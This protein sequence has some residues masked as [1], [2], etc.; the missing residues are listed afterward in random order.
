MAN[1]MMFYYAAPSPQRFVAEAR[2]L[3]LAESA[4]TRDMVATFLGRVMA[5][6]SEHIDG[7][8]AAL[9]DL[10]EHAAAVL[11]LAAWLSDTS[12]GQAHARRDSRFGNP[13][14][15]PPDLLEIEARDAIQLDCLWSWYFA[16]GDV[17]AVAR[18]VSVLRW[19]TCFGAAA[20]YEGSPKTADDQERAL[21]DGLYQAASWSL[22]ALMKQHPPLKRACEDI[23]ESPDLDPTARVALAVCLENV[24]PDGWR[25]ELDPQT[26]VATVKRL[27]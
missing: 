18:V 12:E 27:R 10:P 14:R 19:M 15:R 21:K 3:L 6:N 20:R 22:R 4:Q 8:M 1:W 17:R 24:D 11:R 2:E 23:F 13:P 26:K 16:T 9:E 25:V 7:W 5:A